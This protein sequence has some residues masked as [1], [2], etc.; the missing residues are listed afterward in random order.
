MGIV[1]ESCE[2]TT[3]PQ[4]PGA[5]DYGWIHVKDNLRPQA[6]ARM[7]LLGKL[8]YSK[9]AV[10]VGELKKPHTGPGKT[11]AQKRP[12]KTLSF[13]LG[14]IPRPRAYPANQWG[15]LWHIGTLKRL[16]EVLVLFKC[17][18][19]NNNNERNHKVQENK[20]HSKE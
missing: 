6:E 13:H 19:F 15:L 5:R 20:A 8:R 11:H 3:D 9:T 2:E 16:G 17:P 7:R 14:L 4:T 10:Y 18:V 1:H 12:E